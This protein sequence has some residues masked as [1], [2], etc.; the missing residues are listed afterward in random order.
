MLRRR[1]GGRA[2]TGSN[3]QQCPTS[4][5]AVDDL[6]GCGTTPVGFSSAAF[7][8]TQPIYLQFFSP[9]RGGG[10]GQFMSS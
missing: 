1:A 2:R 4:T 5:N 6:S 7:A 8:L 9:S 10:V 3:K